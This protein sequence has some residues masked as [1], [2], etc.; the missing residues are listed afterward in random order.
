MCHY[1]KRRM[2]DGGTPVIGDQ[3]EP[4]R[5]DKQLAVLNICL[6][7]CAVRRKKRLCP[8][9]A[10]AW[11]WLGQSSVVPPVTR[12]DGSVAGEGGRG[13]EN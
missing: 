10:L 4:A 8:S 2:V 5:Q 7:W 9:I 6:R 1:G 13:L 12:Q 11:A 3:L